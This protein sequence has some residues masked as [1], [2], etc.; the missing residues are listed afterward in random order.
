MRGG[1]WNLGI[2][3]GVQRLTSVSK[4]GTSLPPRNEG[5]PAWADLSET[6]RK[7]FARQQEVF[8]GFLE[9]CTHVTERTPCLRV[10]I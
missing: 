6:E 4:P 2:V 3:A 9:Q 7:V 5:V 8:A 10:R 1:Q